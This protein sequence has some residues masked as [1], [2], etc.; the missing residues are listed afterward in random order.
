MISWYHPGFATR[1]CINKLV[2]HKMGIN[3]S[4]SLI[5]MGVVALSCFI[6]LNN[7]HGENHVK[8]SESA[9]MI[10]VITFQ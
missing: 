7:A 1:S 3:N 6:A 5:R 10:K 4:M 8:K 9:K 2:L